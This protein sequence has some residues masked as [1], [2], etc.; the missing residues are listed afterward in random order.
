[1]HVAILLPCDEIVVIA[2]VQQHGSAPHVQ[3]LSHAVDD[4]V[5]G[6]ERTVQQVGCVVLLQDNQRAQRQQLGLDAVNRLWRHQQVALARRYHRVVD[7]FQWLAFRQ[8]A[9]YVIQRL[10]VANHANFHHRGL[11]VIDKRFHLL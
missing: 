11:D 7:E 1:M 10:H 8:N 6:L 9:H 3:Q 5:V 2:A 4:I